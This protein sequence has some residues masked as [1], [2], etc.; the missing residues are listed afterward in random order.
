[1]GFFGVGA[2]IVGAW[3]W[4]VLNI[5]CWICN[6]IH[7][8]KSVVAVV[9]VVVV[10]EEE[11][12]EEDEDEGEGREVLMRNTVLLLFLTDDSRI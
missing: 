6:W 2:W 12:E 1:V 3:C 7:C 9:I 10:E 4:Y 11:E 8:G 5:G